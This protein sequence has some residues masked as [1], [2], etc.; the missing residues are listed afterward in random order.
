MNITRDMI[1]INKL[2]DSIHAAEDAH[3]DGTWSEYA[4]TNG[5]RVWN[6][7][8]HVTGLYT[9]RAWLRGRLHRQNPPEQ[10]RDFNRTMEEQDRPARLDWDATEHNRKI[11]VK[12]A[13]AF[14]IPEVAT[15]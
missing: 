3:R 11:A 8:G 9:L 2:V 7:A 12:V 13:E 4:K 10:I 15:G 1:D 6:Y 5:I 14:M